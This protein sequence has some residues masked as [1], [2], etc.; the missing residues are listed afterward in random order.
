MCVG[1]GPLQLGVV[2][3][4]TIFTHFSHNVLLLFNTMFSPCLSTV[5]PPATL[6]TS[7]VQTSVHHDVTLTCV[8][9][10][11]G[12]GRG[13]GRGWFVIG[14]QKLEEGGDIVEIV[15]LPAKHRVGASRL[16][17]CYAII[18]TG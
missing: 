6:T 18:V 3:V 17:K 4:F 5:H 15:Q 10:T 12:Q 13:Q 1:S 7:D 16:V 9:T 14:W 11:G 8:L 2:L